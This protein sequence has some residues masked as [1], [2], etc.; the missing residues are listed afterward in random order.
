MPKPTLD[1][2]LTDSDPLLDVKP[3]ARTASTEQQ[4]ILDTFAE[5]NQFIDRHKRKPGDTEKASVS[6]RGL[7]MKLNGLL[8]DPG[9]RDL[10]LPYDRHMLLPARQSSNLRLLMRFLKMSFWRPP[11]TIY[12]IWFM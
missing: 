4:R 7:R 5:I 12:S 2:I 10:L 8:N 11:R 6:E 3:T 1:D 9:S